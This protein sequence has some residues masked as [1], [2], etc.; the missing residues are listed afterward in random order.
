MTLRA[1]NVTVLGFL[2]LA[3]AVEQ[4]QGAIIVDRTALQALLGGPGTLEDFESFNIDPGI[5]AIL[6]SATL[7]STSV[8]NG[9][10]PGLVIP[11]VTFDGNPS[12]ILQWNGVGYVGAPSRE[13]LANAQPLVIDFA[14]PTQAFGVDL[15][16]F[17]DFPADATLEVYAGDDTTLLASLNAISLSSS[18]VPVFAGYEDINGIGRL[19]LTQTSSYS[20]IIDNLEFGNIA[21]AVPEPASLMLVGLGTLGLM[22]GKLRR[23]QRKSTTRA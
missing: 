9:Q 14:L 12:S 20:P 17:T 5:A 13:I 7:D 22:A 10:G 21:A 1:M 23:R 8:M 6:N 3:V 16:A 11:G 4:V 2:M 18:G 15:R 19:V